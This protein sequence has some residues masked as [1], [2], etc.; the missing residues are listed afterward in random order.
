MNAHGGYGIE[1]RAPL[2]RKYDRVD[3]LIMAFIGTACMIYLGI[4]TMAVLLVWEA[5]K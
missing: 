3:Y 4:L 5:L 1:S 2:R